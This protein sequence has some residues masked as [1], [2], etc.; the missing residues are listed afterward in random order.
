MLSWSRWRRAPSLG[1]PRAVGELLGELRTAG[2]SD[3]VTVLADWAATEASVGNP[4]NVA[5]LLGE[6]DAAGASAAVRTLADRAANAGMFDLF[7][8][9]HPAQAPSYGFG[10]EP[11]GTPSQSWRWQEPSLLGP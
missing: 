8:K 11:H 2:A 7:L 6:L 1:D 4:G 9:A 3:A 10:R 5:Q